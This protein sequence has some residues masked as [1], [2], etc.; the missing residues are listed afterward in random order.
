M[1]VYPPRRATGSGNSDELTTN[2]LIAVYTVEY[3]SAEGEEGMRELGMAVAVLLSALPD[4]RVWA[5]PTYY[6]GET[7]SQIIVE[8]LKRKVFEGS[9]DYNAEN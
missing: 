8:G 6:K 7:R 9:P 2:D 5:K 1:A 3:D 4:D